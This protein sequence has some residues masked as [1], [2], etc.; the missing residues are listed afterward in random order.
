MMTRVK[1][2]KPATGSRAF[3]AC[4]VS[5]AI[6]AVLVLTGCGKDELT[7][8]VPQAETISILHNDLTFSAQGATA[9]VSVSA[10]APV[11][12]TTDANWCSAS[13]S[14]TTVSVT[15][16]P[17]TAFEGRTALLTIAS[18][19]ATRTLPVQQRGM[20]LGSLPVSSHY[21]PNSGDSFTYTIAH[22][23]PMTI[24][25]SQPWIHADIDGEQLSVAIDKNELGHIR[26]GYVVC[27]SAGYTDTLAIAQYDI[28]NDIVGSYYMMGYF[29][30]SGGIASAT[31]F[32]IVRQGDDLFMNWTNNDNWKDTLL[33]VS[34]DKGTAT[35]FFPSAM[36]FY[37]SGSS[38]DVGYFYDTNGII[39][40]SSNYGASA[41]MTYNEAT[42]YD[43]AVL[44]AAN[45]P[46]HELAGFIIRSSR[47]GGLVVTTLL[48]L[49]SPVVMHVGP[50]GTKISD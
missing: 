3:T 20:V 41:R 2:T 29:G 45:W 17:N 14:G 22:D 33:P 26:R 25:A 16:E 4:L 47:G 39:A 36:T 31:R 6:G 1:S 35:L 7:G 27:Q 18:G 46:G 8:Y 15:V 21:S 10:D 23:L 13:V 19:A 44:T 32:D 40:A 28:D 30:G 43:Q 37:S 49:G 9:T 38:A 12:A 42:G 24:E 5:C 34:L 48:Q 11:T 50:V